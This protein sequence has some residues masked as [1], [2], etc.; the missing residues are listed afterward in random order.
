ME[1]FAAKL[2]FQYRSPEE[3]SGSYFVVEEKI[4]VIHANAAAD[5][6]KQFKARG[7]ADEFTFIN[8]DGIAM[9]FQF[10]GVV[11]MIVLGVEAAEDECWYSVRKMKAPL[12]RIPAESK[13][14]AMKYEQRV[15]ATS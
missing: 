11:E 1:R 7:A 9:E 2:L 15:R 4:V 12:R 14:S 10:V 13:L 8:A 3:S 5:A 6:L